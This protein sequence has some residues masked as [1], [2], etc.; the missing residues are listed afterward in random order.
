MGDLD[1][2]SLTERVLRLGR[3]PPLSRMTTDELALLALAGREVT[4]TRRTVL[5]PAEDR[6]PALYVPLTGRLRAVRGGQ[7]VPG[8]PIRDFY[9]GT[10]LLSRAVISADVVAEPG[11]ALFVLDRDVFFA[12]LEEHGALARS[13]LHHMS[14]RLIELRGTDII[15]SGAQVSEGQPKFVSSDLLTRMRLLR[16]ALGVEPRAMPVIAQLARATHVRNLTARAILW[17]P[18]SDVARFVVVAKGLVEILRNG[19]VVSQVHAGEGIGMAEAI[20]MAPVSY[21]AVAA[22]ETT[23]FELSCAEMQEAIDDHDDFCLDLIRVISLELHKRMFG[24]LI[25]SN[26]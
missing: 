6:A 3:S 2:A 7:A 25:V 5:V 13:M 9:G 8:D 14:R 23:A 15:T 24:A 26:A 21:G 12:L 16:D 4:Y 18:S 10:S 11:T 20:A 1:P 22:A 19:L 17:E